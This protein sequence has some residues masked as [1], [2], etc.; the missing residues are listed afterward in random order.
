MHIFICVLALLN[1]ALLIA[2]FTAHK[3]K[4][5]GLMRAVGV[6]YLLLSVPAIFA[7]AT[8]PLP[9]THIIFLCIFLAYLVIECLYDYIL[10]VD[11]RRNFKLLIPYLAL[12]YAMNYG[13]FVMA[14]RASPTYGY[15]VLAV[16][17]VQIAVNLWSHKWKKRE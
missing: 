11:F 17:V 10:K 9:G 15:I 2:I 8:F 1:S 6:A 13:F 14:H 7:L 5:L 4:R 12:Y 3:K 16:T